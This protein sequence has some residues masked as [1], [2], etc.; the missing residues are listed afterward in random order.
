MFSHEVQTYQYINM[1]L[2]C[3]QKKKQRTDTHTEMKDFLSFQQSTNVMCFYLVVGAVPIPATFVYNNI[4]ATSLN[5]EPAE[6]ILCL[7]DE[8]KQSNVFK[9]N[10]AKFV[11]WTD[12]AFNLEEPMFRCR[13]IRMQQA[14]F[15]LLPQCCMVAINFC[16]KSEATGMIWKELELSS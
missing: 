16:L 15:I 11:K 13:D 7:I 12:P 8:Y 10:H 1:D 5:V 3:P 4:Q 2:Q 6:F 14:G 9:P